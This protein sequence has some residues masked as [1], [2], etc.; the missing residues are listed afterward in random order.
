MGRTR[1]RISAPQTRHS[2]R[3]GITCS[4]CCSVLPGQSMCPVGTG[5]KH[6]PPLQPALSRTCPSRRAGIGPPLPAGSNPAGTARTT[7][8]PQRTL[9]GTPCRASAYLLPPRMSRAHQDMFGTSS[10]PLLVETTPGGTLDTRHPPTMSQARRQSTPHYNGC[11]EC[12]TPA[13]T[14][15]WCTR[16]LLRPC[17]HRASHHLGWSRSYHRE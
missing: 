1:P 7:R 8:L 12:A 16:P 6:S 17:P 3:L 14:S 4:C 5:H 11:T 9:E 2:R 15:R 13:C 10:C